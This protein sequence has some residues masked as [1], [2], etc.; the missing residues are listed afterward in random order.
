MT[1]KHTGPS[2][3]E[4]FSI[5]LPQDGSAEQFL[6]GVGVPDEWIDDYRARIDEAI[7]I[8][9]KV[10]LLLSEHSIASVWVSDEVE[11]AFEKELQQGR[12]MLFPVRLDESIMRTDQAWAAKLRR[13]RHIGD[14]TTWEIS[15]QKYQSAFDRL[16]RDLK[17]D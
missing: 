15:A 17:Q 9:E 13:E 4:L 5:Q 12:N 10:L 14:F 1:I 8:H 11:A 16:L 6:R 2:Y 3:L 7:H